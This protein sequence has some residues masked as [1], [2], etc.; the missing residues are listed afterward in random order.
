MADPI[1]QSRHLAQPETDAVQNFVC[2]LVLARAWNIKARTNLRP[3]VVGKRSHAQDFVLLQLE[4][5]K[6][7]THPS[8]PSSCATSIDWTK[9][10]YMA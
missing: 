3:R 7:V 2:G 10:L 9:S 1:A 8:I 6:I 5:R 4:K